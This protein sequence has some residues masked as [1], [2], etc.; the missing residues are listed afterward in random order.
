MY[1]GR[2]LSFMKYKIIKLFTI[3]SLLFPTM[4]AT[5]ENNDIPDTIEDLLIALEKEN[6]QEDQNNNDSMDSSNDFSIYDSPKKWKDH[7]L[8]N[9]ERLMNTGNIVHFKPI[10]QVDFID[11]EFMYDAIEVNRLFLV[12]L[13]NGLKCI[14]KVYNKEQLKR[15]PKEVIIYEISKVTELGYCIPTI[16]RTSIFFRNKKLMGSLQLYVKEMYDRKREKP[17]DESDVVNLLSP[18]KKDVLNSWKV[19]NYLF[20]SWTPDIQNIIVIDNI[21]LN[22]EYIYLDNIQMVNQFGD[23]P[24]I[25]YHTFNDF[26]TNEINVYDDI[27]KKHE[28]DLVKISKDRKKKQIEESKKKKR[29]EKLRKEAEANAKKNKN[30]PQQNPYNQQYPQQ[31]PYNQQYPQQNSYNQQ[32]PQQNQQNNPTNNENIQS[33]ELI[34]HQSIVDIFPY[35]SNQFFNPLNPNQYDVVVNKYC[36]HQPKI[37]HRYILFDKAYWLRYEDPIVVRCIKLLIFPNEVHLDT[38]SKIERVTKGK[39]FWIFNKYKSKNL[40]PYESH[41]M[42]QDINKIIDGIMK[43]CDILLDKFMP[44]SKRKELEQ[45]QKEEEEAKKKILEEQQMQQYQQYQQQQMMQYPQ[46]YQYPQQ[47]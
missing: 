2:Y 33:P 28:E 17:Q 12:T 40:S 4:S 19:F 10:R 24:F 45:K 13:D 6:N 42:S 31:N 15:L 38:Y 29:E 46:Y 35:D 14:F 22:N 26:E 34:E 21:P 8:L 30:N 36:Y 16:W 43:R 27:N 20:G 41:I 5:T 18:V 7:D 1:I 3:C 9:I 25:R 37:L 11:T 39:L 32:Y 23:I 47:Y 44:T